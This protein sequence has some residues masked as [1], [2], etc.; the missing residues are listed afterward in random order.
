MATFYNFALKIETIWAKRV[1]IRNVNDAVVCV[2][3]M[4]SRIKF[5]KNT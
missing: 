2:W 3:F 4:H 1:E 5:F